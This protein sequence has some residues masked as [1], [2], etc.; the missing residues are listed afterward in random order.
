M[1]PLLSRHQGRELIVPAIANIVSGVTGRFIGLFCG[2]AD[3]FFH[4]EPRKGVLVDSRKPLIAFY[5]AVQREPDA[6]YDELQLLIKRAFSER[7]FNQ[8]LSKWNGKDFGVLFAAKLLYLNRSCAPGTFAVDQGQRFSATW[9]GLESLPGLPSLDDM[10]R[11]SAALKRMRLYTKDY[12]YVL[13]AA[14]KGDVVYVDAPTW[15][16]A[17][18]YGGAMFTESDQIRLA[19]L[20]RKASERGVSIVVSSTDCDAVQLMYGGWADTETFNNGQLLVSAMG[21]SVDRRQM[22]LFG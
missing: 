2:A 20:L 11:A 6:V 14:R 1:D 3:V 15:G 8:I 9:G 21:S 4:V 18:S 22:S 16:V 10:R 19:R 12:A 5:E 13:R 7:T 17:I